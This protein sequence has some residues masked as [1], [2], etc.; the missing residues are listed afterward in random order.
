[1]LDGY[2]P[3][4]VWQAAMIIFGTVS[5]FPEKLATQCAPG[6][7]RSMNGEP[8]VHYVVRSNGKE[9]FTP[10]QRIME[11][12]A[13]SFGGGDIQ[14]GNALVL[15]HDDLEFRDTCLAAKIRGIRSDPTIAVAGLIGSRGA[16][17]LAWWEGQRF[18]RVTDDAYG[19]HDFPCI[20]EKTPWPR[21]VDSL[22]GM[23]LILNPW[24]CN[25]LR[26]EDIGYEGFHGYADDLCY[27]AR[28]LG[29]RTVV[30]DITAHHHSKGGY[31]GGVSTWM[32]ANANFRKRWFT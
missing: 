30:A 7:A 15:L 6:I 25:Q 28:R 17:G 13:R 2:H 27:Q 16:Q 31:A 9:I 24:A 1:M 10:Y 21:R 23:C 4:E 20:E 8:Y 29:M 14:D 19:L 18:G 3:R 26:L 5:G 11:Y 12:A 22:D 32:A